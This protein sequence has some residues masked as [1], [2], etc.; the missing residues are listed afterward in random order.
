[1]ASNIHPKEIPDVILLVGTDASGKDHIANLLVEMIEEAD[2][3]V[4]KRKQYITGKHKE[5]ESGSQKSRIELIFEWFILHTFKVLGGIAPWLMLQILK[6]DL[7][8]DQQSDKK[9]IVIGHNC[10]RGLAFYWGHKYKTT[11]QISVSPSLSESLAQLR[12]IRGLHVVVLDVEDK[13]RRKRIIRRKQEGEADYFDQYMA[14]DSA[15]SERIEAFLV[16]LTRTYLGGV[17]IE[18]ND[19]SKDELLWLIQASFPQKQLKGDKGT[20]IP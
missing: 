7:Q 6:R 15:R 9:L 1:M 2:G 11:D 10:L 16:W 8:K 3:E 18:N 20:G 4:V 5:K 17:L 19:L 12:S 14:A 13:I